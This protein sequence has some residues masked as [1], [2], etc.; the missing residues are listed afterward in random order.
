MNN[1]IGHKCVK[2]KW[3]QNVY[4]IIIKLVNELIFSLMLYF[5]NVTNFRIKVNFVQIYQNSIIFR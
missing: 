1:R 2:Y 5:L 3:S 4:L